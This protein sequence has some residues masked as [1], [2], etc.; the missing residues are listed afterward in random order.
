MSDDK[1]NGG[2]ELPSA[3]PRD[4]R[5]LHL[6]LA[7]MG[8]SSYQDRVPLQLMD[9]AYRYTHGVLQDALHY[10]DHANV[11]PSSTLPA[12][13]GPSHAPLTTEDVRL[14][15]AARTNYQFKP[16]PPKELL[17]ELAQERNKRPLPA[18]SQTWGLRLPPEKYCLT[19]KE[20][21]MDEEADVVMTEQVEVQNN[22][23][24]DVEM[25]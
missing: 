18:V 5:L 23:S 2:E 25:S 24:S 10:N 12:G 20:W 4:V 15:V 6:I 13:M 1:E 19:S 22:Q 14:A 9:F 21:E 8:V 7:S 11:N 17:L 16:A 3:T